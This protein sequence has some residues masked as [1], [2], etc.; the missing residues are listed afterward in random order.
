VGILKVRGLRMGTPDRLRHV[1]ATY[2]PL[3]V[4]TKTYFL[5]LG[6][7]LRKERLVT[8]LSGKREAESGGD[9][10]DTVIISFI[11]KGGGKPTRIIYILYALRPAAEGPLGLP[12]GRGNQKEIQ[13]ND[14]KNRP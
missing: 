4:I 12:K 11:F 1:D 2:S 14:R 5:L 10:V 8:V 3:V 13:K 9:T 6:V 7:L